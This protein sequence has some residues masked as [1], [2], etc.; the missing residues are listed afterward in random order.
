[1]G[2]AW[3]LIL[4]KPPQS[5]RDVAFLPLSSRFLIHFIS[6]IKDLLSSQ[7]LLPLP[8]PISPSPSSLGRVRSLPDIN[9]P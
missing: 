2:G 6:L 9:P 3:L 1:M 8:F 5:E 4:Q 7:S